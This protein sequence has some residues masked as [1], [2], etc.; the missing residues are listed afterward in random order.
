MVERIIFMRNE[1]KYTAIN[2][3]SEIKCF[4]SES[5]SE[6]FEIL[7]QSEEDIGCNKVDF[8]ENTFS[9]LREQ[10]SKMKRV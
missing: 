1:S 10:L 7:K 2:F 3:Q 9:D 4:L 5:Q 8:I 6:L